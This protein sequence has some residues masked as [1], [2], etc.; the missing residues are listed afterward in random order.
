MASKDAEDQT[1]KR[2]ETNLRNSAADYADY[3][4]NTIAKL[5]QTCLKKNPP[6]DHAHSTGPQRASDKKFHLFPKPPKPKREPERG[7]SEEPSLEDDCRK[8]VRQLNI[9]RSTRAENLEDGYNEPET[10]CNT[11]SKTYHD[12]A[13]SAKPGVWRALN[14]SDGSD[15]TGSFRRAFSIS[16]PP[17]TLY[18][19]YRSS[20][21]SNLVFG[22]P[23]VDPTVNQHWSREGVW[24]LTKFIGRFY[25][26]RYKWHGS[27]LR[28][29]IESEEIFS[30]SSSDNIYAVAMLLEDSLMEDLIQNA[31]TLF[32][33]PIS[34]SPPPSAR[35]RSRFSAISYSSLFAST[36][37]AEPHAIDSE[38]SASARSFSIIFPS[39]SSVELSTPPRLPNF[40]PSPLMGLS[41]LETPTD[42]RD[43]PEPEQFIPEQRSPRL[44]CNEFAIE[45]E[46][47][48]PNS[49][50][51]SYNMHAFYF[52]TLQ[53]HG[54]LVFWA[55]WS[56]IR[57]WTTRRRMIPQ[58]L[59]RIECKHQDR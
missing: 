20:G 21:Y 49:M 48:S 3:A 31:H 26:K 33:E 44:L 32:D 23:V 38:G 10:F 30:F 15:L 2:L 45:D 51:V 13:M 24:V 55:H 36:L 6:R 25:N 9:I 41:P 4:E 37:F 11:T 57:G 7:E 29:R 17:L 19:N 18:R 12:L 58:L 40:L 56:L 8:A 16:V 52:S 22:V 39:V 28:R 35:A 14:G 54:Y 53:F 27:S 47:F 34:P 43:P 59:W 46:D 5:Q 1:R 50:N 42:G